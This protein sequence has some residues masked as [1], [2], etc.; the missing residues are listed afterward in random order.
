MKL[1]LNPQAGKPLSTLKE[2]GLMKNLYVKPQDT[3]NHAI[4]W[5][6]DYTPVLIKFE[7]RAEQMNPQDYA[8]ARR[9]LA[10]M[11]MAGLH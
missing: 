6:S 4:P 9:Y 7:E 10:R 2:Q 1:H 5:D 8:N 3:Q 11:E